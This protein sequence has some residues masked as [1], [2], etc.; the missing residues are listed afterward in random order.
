MPIGRP[1]E[2]VD[3]IIAKGRKHLT[4]CEIKQRRSEE[5][6]VPSDCVIAPEYLTKKQRSEFNRISVQLIDLGI[7]TN[8][9]VDALAAYIVERDAWIDA[10]RKLRSKTV[11]SDPFALKAWSSAESRFRQQMRLAASDLGLTIT[12]RGK[13]IVPQREQEAPRENK[14]A[15]FAKAGDP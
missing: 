11:R 4:K 14:F 1:R 3:L 12:S 6:D 9:D 13:L 2:P 15:A 5:L 7:M 8:L 10:V